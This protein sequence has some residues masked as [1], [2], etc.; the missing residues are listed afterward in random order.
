MNRPNPIHPP[1]SMEPTASE[2]TPSLSIIVF[3]YN[4]AENIPVVLGE[5]AEYLRAHEPHAEVVMVDDGSTDETLQAA[6]RVLA[7]VPS[8]FVRHERNKGIGAALKS[9]VRAAR[10]PWVTFLP[11]DGQVPPEAVTT[12]MRSATEHDSDVV[13]SVYTRRDD[14]WIRKVHSVGVRTLIWAVHG[15]R[16]R[17]E[18][19]YLFRRRLF[20]PEELPPDTFFLN[21]EFPIRVLRGGLRV[22]TVAIP[23]RQ[24][25]AGQS[26][27][28]S[29]RR[30][31]G[32]G[33]DLL[34]LKFRPKP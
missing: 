24:R 4:E 32:V 33:V 25:F 1:Q 15:V 20:V 9:G 21:Y 22:S 10:A 5:L 7:S 6:Q 3:A 29:I 27:S 8:R 13:L 31:L 19:P 11:A 34:K 26:K 28:T 14:G 17:S 18:G 30:I 23:C 16:L 2:V 12:L